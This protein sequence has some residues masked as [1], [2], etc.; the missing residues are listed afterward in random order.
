MEHLFNSTMNGFLNAASLSGEIVDNSDK[1]PEIQIGHPTDVRHVAHIGWDGPSENSPS[2]MHE[3]KSV[4]GISS[5]PP[6]VNGDIQ[7]KG[8]ENS[9]R[10]PADP[11]RRDS[12]SVT[13]EG[14]ERDLSEMPRSSKRHS[15]SSGNMRESHAKEKSDRPRHSK[16]SSKHSHSND[17]FNGTN[18][19]EQSMHMDSDS[20]QLHGGDLPPKGLQDIPKRTHSNSKKTKDS[21]NAVSNS[22]LRTKASHPKDPN[23]NEGEGPHARSSSK[24]KNKLRPCGEDGQ[25]GRESSNED[26]LRNYSNN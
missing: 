9:A 23:S 3:F 24:P 17:S 18:T 1:E 20:L 14:H 6:N 26:L 2:W 5:T 7:C 12:R 19:T 13:C 15:N 4:P 16:R 25:F 8:Q 21:S 22:K 10:V 11:T